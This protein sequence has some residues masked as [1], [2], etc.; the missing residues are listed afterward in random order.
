GSSPFVQQQGTFAPAD[1]ISRWM[2]SVA[3]NGAGEIA[4]GYSASDGSSVFPSVRY[5]GRLAAD[6][7]GTMTIAETTMVA[8][9]GS[10]TGYPRWGDYSAMSV[11]PTDDHTFWYTQEYYSSTSSAGWK[12]RIG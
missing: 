11:D 6:A 1:G 3:M 7:A 4:L 9:G 5:T 10:Q 8:G 12:T 2:G